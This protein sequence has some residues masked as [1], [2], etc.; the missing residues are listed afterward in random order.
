MMIEHEGR[1]TRVLTYLNTV[2]GPRRDVIDFEIQY[3]I[4]N[5]PDLGPLCAVS[6]D[7]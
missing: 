3:N 5:I 7:L 6:C 1:D 2:R 4:V